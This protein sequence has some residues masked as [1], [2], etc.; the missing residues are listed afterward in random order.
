M[1]DIF[2]MRAVVAKALANATRL[3]IVDLL[4]G[5]GPTCVCEMAEYL[6]ESQ[7][8]ISKHLGILREAG[9][10]S[11]KKDGSMVRYELNMKCVGNFFQCIDDVIRR[12]VT[13]KQEALTIL[14][15]PGRDV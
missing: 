11:A 15:E 5:K 13:D 6:E 10:V 9:I 4:L 3:R 8:T 2:A 1:Q 12:D 7:P 14:I